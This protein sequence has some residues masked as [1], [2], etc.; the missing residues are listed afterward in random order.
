M[1]ARGPSSF[2]TLEGEIVHPDH[3]EDLNTKRVSEGK[4]YYYSRNLE[5][6]AIEQVGRGNRAI[7]AIRLAHGKTTE[8]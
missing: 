4:Q 8:S 1:A 6:L 7:I 5:Q 3:C 2:V